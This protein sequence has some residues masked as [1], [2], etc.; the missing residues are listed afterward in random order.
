MSCA[1]HA[2]PRQQSP[3]PASEFDGYS[4]ICK[5]TKHFRPRSRLCQ[6]LCRAICVSGAALSQPAWNP[7]LWGQTDKRTHPQSSGRTRQRHPLLRAIMATA[8]K[9][10]KSV[11]IT[12]C[13]IGGLG[14][15]L[16]Q[17]FAAEGCKVMS[18]VGRKHAVVRLAQQPGSVRVSGR[19]SV[20]ATSVGHGFP[21]TSR[22]P[23]GCST[24]GIA[25]RCSGVRNSPPAGAHARAG[26]AGL[27]AAAPGH[28]RPGL[29][30]RR[31]QACALACHWQTPAPTPLN[32]A[33]AAFRFLLLSW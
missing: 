27:H 17:E 16:C 14:Y 11:L 25:S 19:Q 10:G 4:H 18:H 3:H 22:T 24:L 13:S 5:S 15:A 20:A 23:A 9:S 26:G 21:A 31:S 33:L 28:H 32:N 29:H 12:G 1:C 8:R 6:R 7:S 30:R 2:G